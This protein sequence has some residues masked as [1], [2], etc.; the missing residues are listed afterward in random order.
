MARK[1][2]LG[3]GQSKKRSPYDEAIE[4]LTS[5]VKK[6]PEEALRLAVEIHKESELEIH[7][8]SEVDGLEIHE[9]IEKP[10]GSDFDLPY[11]YENNNSSNL[12][13]KGELLKISGTGLFDVKY[14]HH[15]ISNVTLRW[16]MYK[17]RIFT[18]AFLHPVPPSS[19][20]GFV[21]RPFVFIARRPLNMKT[22]NVVLD[23]ITSGWRQIR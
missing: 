14:H 9:E 15:K 18:Y 22:K 4:A 19:R 16:M 8:E 2:K 7:E 6:T 20:G 21:E 23:D 3:W 12:V 10:Y 5:S 11:K 13:L 17:G 1:L